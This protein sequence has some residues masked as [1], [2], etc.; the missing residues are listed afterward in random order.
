MWYKRNVDTVLGA[1]SSSWTPNYANVVAYY[2]FDETSG[3]T[4]IVDAISARNGTVQNTLTL[5][6]AG[7]I[8]TCATFNGTT[9]WINI[10]SA[11]INN[12]SSGTIMC[13]VYPKS[14]T[15]G[16][17]CIKQHD[18]I[19]T[20]AG[21]TIGYYISTGGGNTAGTSGIVYWH[22]N[23]NQSVG[24]SASASAIPINT[25]THITVTFTSTTVKIYFNGVLNSTTS[26]NGSIPDDT[27]CTTSIGG[28]YAG[29]N[30]QNTFNGSID[31]FSV[32]NTELTS[33]NISLIYSAL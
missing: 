21:L 32:W 15:S 19:A 17:I 28:W 12:I 18:G 27:T 24:A 7:M 20:F 6:S 4:T 3:S 29:G 33:A 11:A 8:N 23:N 2:K 10:P 13:W 26:T 22:S 31:D 5:G 9:S 16:T 14:L 25:W 30:L 1:L